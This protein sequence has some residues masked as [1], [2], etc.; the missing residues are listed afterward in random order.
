M[1]MFLTNNDKLNISAATTFVYYHGKFCNSLEVEI[2]GLF[3]IS[4]LPYYK[5]SISN[6]GFFRNVF[7]IRG[8]GYR[9]QLVT[10]NHLAVSQVLSAEFNF[11][12]DRSLLS[13]RLCRGLVH[14]TNSFNDSEFI[15]PK[16]LSV[17][18][19]YS[20]N[21]YLPIPDF[22]GIK[23]G[24][25]DR[26]LT[27]YGSHKQLV[28]N[29]SKLVYNFRPPSVYTGRGIRFKKIIHRRK[30]GKKDIRKGRFF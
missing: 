26:K 10:S 20:Y 28:S 13:H 19:G 27:I 21:L 11:L 14:K 5:R 3:S 29:F 22:I 8:I 6:A 12:P 24:K 17:R 4:S 23:I 1:A 9:A 7:I 18:V 15:Y 30:L 16:Y 25:K 2:L